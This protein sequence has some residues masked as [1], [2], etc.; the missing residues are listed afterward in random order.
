MTT[1]TRPS[2]AFSVEDLTEALR[3][4]RIGV[5]DWD[6]PGNLLRWSDVSLKIYGMQPE[7]LDN[8]FG[9]VHAARSSR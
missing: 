2:Q 3:S 4:A 1:S 9:I 5:W 8:S 7:D 6:I